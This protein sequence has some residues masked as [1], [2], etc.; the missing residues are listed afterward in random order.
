M[1]VTLLTSLLI[2]KLRYQH[3]LKQRAK[4]FAN[5]IAVVS[6]NGTSCLSCDY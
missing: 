2:Q 4:Y 3:T 5:L 6:A 1:S